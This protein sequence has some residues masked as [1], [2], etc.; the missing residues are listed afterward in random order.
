MRRE[1]RLPEDG[2]QEPLGQP[3]GRVRPSASAI[4]V[5]REGILPSRRL[6][7]PRRLLIRRR[8]AGRSVRP[9]GRASADGQFTSR[10][11]PAHFGLGRRT[12]QCPSTGRTIVGALLSATI[13]ETGDH[14]L[15]SIMMDSPAPWTGPRLTSQSG[16][17]RTSPA[18]RRQRPDSGLNR[19]RGSISR[20]LAGRAAP[21]LVRVSSTGTVTVAEG[22]PTRRPPPTPAFLAEPLQRLHCPSRLG[23]SGSGVTR[24]GPLWLAARPRQVSARS[25]SDMTLS[26]PPAPLGP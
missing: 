23:E 9:Y 12:S 26:P 5:T 17:T 22:P 4:R 11:I 14:G 3:R 6:A 25:E 20:P 19:R 10:R 7:R 16:L 15:G 1:K 21:D 8:L 2:P 24:R 13:A 18:H